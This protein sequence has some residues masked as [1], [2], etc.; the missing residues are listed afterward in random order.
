[1]RY[2][3]QQQYGEWCVIDTAPGVS[4][5]I[6]VGCPIGRGGTDTGREY[7]E[8]IAQGLN[9]TT[10]LLETLET[11]C[12]GLAWNIEN[13]PQIMG[14]ADDEALADARRVLA[15]AAELLMGRDG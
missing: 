13:H 6:A 10:E 7:A 14:Q 1:M 5:T 15:Q 11:L 8:R 3:T 9:A 4:V 2:I 12:N